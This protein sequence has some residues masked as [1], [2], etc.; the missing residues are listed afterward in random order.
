MF[1]KIE[2]TARRPFRHLSQV[3]KLLLRPEDVEQ[4]RMA[5]RSDFGGKTAK[6]G[7]KR[8]TISG[9]SSSENAKVDRGRAAGAERWPL[10]RKGTCKRRGMLRFM[11]SGAARPK[12]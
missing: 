1:W 11:G 3:K 12:M 5:E 9:N 10:L 2:Q 7:I 4:G 6:D 8:K